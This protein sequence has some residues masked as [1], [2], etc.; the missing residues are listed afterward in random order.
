MEIIRHQKDG[1]SYE[2]HNDFQWQIKRQSALYIPQSD[3]ESVFQTLV[4]VTGAQVCSHK[5]NVALKIL[6]QTTDMGQ[7]TYQ[8][9]MGSGFLCRPQIQELQS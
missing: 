2:L 8:E 7:L 6:R 4:K 3:L 5:R 9:E 1:N